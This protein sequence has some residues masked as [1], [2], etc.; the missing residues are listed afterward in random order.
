MI[1]CEMTVGDVRAQLATLPDASVHCVVTSPQYLADADPVQ[2]FRAL[3]VLLHRIAESLRPAC[4]ADVAPASCHPRPLASLLHDHQA[5]RVVSLWCLDS[6]VGT[7]GSK[8]RCGRDR[9]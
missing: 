6:E 7:N 2:P 3:V 5:H 1:R 9:A 8:R 4:R